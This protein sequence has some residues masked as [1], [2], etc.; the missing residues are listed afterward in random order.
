[1]R[2]GEIVSKNRKKG[3]TVI[4]FFT[5]IFSG[6]ILIKG[7]KYELEEES[8]LPENE[9]VEENE[10][11]IMEYT[12]EYTVPI[13]VKSKNGNVL[14]KN[15]LV[16]MLNVE[17]QIHENFGVE[18]L[19][20]ADVISSI[21]LS[22]NNVTNMSYENKIRAINGVGDAKITQIFDFPFFPEDYISLLLSKD[23]DGK[24]AGSSVI[25]VP[26]NGSLIKNREEALKGEEKIEEICKKNSIYTDKYVIGTRI[27]SERIMK[28]NS[29][30]LSFILP[31]S[32]ILIILVLLIIWCC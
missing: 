3:I 12:N 4:I 17:K 7:I 27:I 29:K 19:S 14:E 26:L 10:R 28:E 1:M 5:L 20:I 32:F 16:E 9:I 31:L 23:F 8:F 15:D 6:I 24:K 25:K 11:I 2:I 21:L 30:S 22:L 18:S 13:L